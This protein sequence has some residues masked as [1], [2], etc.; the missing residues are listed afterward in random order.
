MLEWVKLIAKCFTPDD[1]VFAGTPDQAMY[2]KQLR[3]EIER[4]GVPS[5][6]IESEIEDWLHAE[7]SNAGHIFAQMALVRQFFAA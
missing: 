6:L 5:H 2:A 3:A 1:L 4:S 7:C